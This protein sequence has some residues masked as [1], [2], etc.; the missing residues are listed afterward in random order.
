M[1]CIRRVVLGPAKQDGRG[2]PHILAYS[3]RRL[4]MVNCPT[5]QRYSYP[6]IAPRVPLVLSPEQPCVLDARREPTICLRNGYRY[7]FFYLFRDRP[8]V[9]SGPIKP[10][11]LLSRCAASFGATAVFLGGTPAVQLLTSLPS[12]RLTHASLFGRTCAQG[13]GTSLLLLLHLLNPRPPSFVAHQDDPSRSVLTD[14]DSQSGDSEESR[15]DDASAGEESEA[16]DAEEGEAESEEEQ[17]ESSAKE[18]AAATQ[19][20]ERRRPVAPLFSFPPGP[21]VQRTE[22]EESLQVSKAV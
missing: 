9:C 18:G 15:T 14:D 8:T 10:W 16:G 13:Q 1:S 17:E 6:V 7:V 2:G 19:E 11:L 3:A 20:G 22:A 4:A 12:F 21:R 5:P